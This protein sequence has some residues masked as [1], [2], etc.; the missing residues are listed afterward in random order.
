MPNKVCY[1]LS[2]TYSQMVVI[3]YLKSIVAFR[4]FL[5]Y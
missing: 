1:I 5:V 3:G 4:L 2:H